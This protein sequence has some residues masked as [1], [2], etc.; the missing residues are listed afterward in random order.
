M[1][2]REA[3]CVLWWVGK[4]S[5]F[6]LTGLTSALRAC[7]QLLTRGVCLSLMTLSHVP[8]LSST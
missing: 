6:L 8:K 4:V 1:S 3:W 2:Q 7:S 5:Q